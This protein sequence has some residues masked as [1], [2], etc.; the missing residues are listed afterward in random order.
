MLKSLV[1]RAMIVSGYLWWVTA[2]NYGVYVIFC[3]W[4]R[5]IVRALEAGARIDGNS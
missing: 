4:Q 2:P 5:C 1:L 3:G